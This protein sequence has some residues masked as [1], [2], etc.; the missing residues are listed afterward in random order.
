MKVADALGATI[1]PHMLAPGN[2][3]R[4]AKDSPSGR[5]MNRPGHSGEQTTPR[6]NAREKHLSK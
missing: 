3:T 1:A 4:Q 5:K 2:Q 6:G